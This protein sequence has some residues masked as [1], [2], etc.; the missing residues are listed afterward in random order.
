MLKALSILEMFTFLSWRFGHEEKPLD[1]KAK[2]N[3][4]IY[5]V[6]DWIKNNDN[7]DNTHIAQQLR[8]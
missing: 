1:K 4:E 2:V 8:K 5:D 3:F 6:T 7:S